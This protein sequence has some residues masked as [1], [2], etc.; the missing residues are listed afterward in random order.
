M[1]WLKSALNFGRIQTQIS[2]WIQL[3]VSEA[4]ALL[5]MNK[6]N[7]KLGMFG[8]KSSSKSLLH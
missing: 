4:L 3:F 2:V 7:Q 5:D 1:R 8:F 6:N